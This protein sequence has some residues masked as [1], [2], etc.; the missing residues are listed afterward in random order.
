MNPTVAADPVEVSS[1]AETAE[2][3]AS[4]RASGATHAAIV[5]DGVILNIDF[6]GELSRTIA[7]PAVADLPWLSVVSNGVGLNGE[8]VDSGH[9]PDDPA[10]PSNSPIHYCVSADPA[11]AVV[12]LAVLA[13]VMGQPE[14]QAVFNDII[15][16]GN[17]SGH[18]TLIS[19]RL[20]YAALTPPI[21]TP[22]SDAA[23]PSHERRAQLA[24]YRKEPTVSFVVR[25]AG[26]RPHLLTRA[27]RSIVNELP[28]PSVVEILVVSRAAKEPLE[29]Y[30]A[31][32]MEGTVE[33][34]GTATPV[35][36]LS[37]EETS[38][39]ARTAALIAG[40]ERAQGS[41]VWYVDDDDWIANGA[42]GNVMCAVQADDRPILFGAVRSHAEAWKDGK[43]TDTEV[44]RTYPPQDWHRAFTGWNFIPNCGMVVPREL[45]LSRINATPIQADLAED[46]ALQLLA[47]TA[48]GSTVRVIQQVIAHVSIRGPGENAV[49]MTDRTPWLR[50]VSSHFSELSRDPSASTAAFW[51]IGSAL[52]DTPYAEA[53]ADNPEST[54]PTRTLFSSL[55]DRIP[56]S[57]ST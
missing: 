15:Q 6:A 4:R 17:G 34:A 24:R 14:T 56:R 19:S 23:P 26:D 49:A 3:L 10:S 54:P 7:D 35:R 36:P 40:L 52:R 25:T 5:A 8:H 45:A 46:Y 50:D 39:P 22:R 51:S 31:A 29:S 53:D 44:G 47:V 13:S 1:W 37:I 27:L 20:R 42:L 28:D 11:I 32:A 41:Y 12:N 30:V 18:P 55:K 57:K 48:P 16:L 43:L 9:Y 21:V 33:S 2:T 38:T